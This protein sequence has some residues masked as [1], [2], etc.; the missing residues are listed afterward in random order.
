MHVPR[1]PVELG[2]HYGALR[3]AGHRQRRSQLRPT[4]QGVVALAGFHLH[5]LADQI[6]TLD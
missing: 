4:L 1:Q 6:V 3:L 5:E 2:H